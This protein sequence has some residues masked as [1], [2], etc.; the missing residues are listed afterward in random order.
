M[1]LQAYAG[2]A[3]TTDM[4]NNLRMQMVVQTENQEVVDSEELVPSEIV[5][6]VQSGATYWFHSIIT[7]SAGHAEGNGGSGG[8]RWNWD[9]PVGTAMPRQNL[10]YSLTDSGN[11][12][13][14]QGG[15]MISRSP[16]SSTQMR[17]QGTGVD[18]FLAVHE[19]GTIQVGGQGG[20]CTLQFAQWGESST[21]TIL[22]GILR[23]RALWVRVL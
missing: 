1:P 2:Q 18:N 22:R 13:L 11:T 10:A 9:T 5:I 3:I 8:F 21:P 14:I 15:T 23:T 17:A 7:Y 12:G 19:S 16:S 6:P 20:D 4:L